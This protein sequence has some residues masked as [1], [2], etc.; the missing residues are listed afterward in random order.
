MSP[1]SYGVVPFSV[2]RAKRKLA[3][4]VKVPEAMKPGQPL[5]IRYHADRPAKIC[6][7]SPA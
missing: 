4:E 5:K 2:S 6:Q 3:L 7:R 1:L